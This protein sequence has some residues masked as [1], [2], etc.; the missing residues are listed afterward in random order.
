MEELYFYYVEFL[1]SATYTYN[2]GDKKCLLPFLC[3]L[4][5]S[6]IFG[7]IQILH[8]DTE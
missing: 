3:V 4:Y 2:T 7:L 8:W 5:I 1:K 6:K